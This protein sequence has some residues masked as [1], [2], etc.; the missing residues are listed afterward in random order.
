MHRIAGGDDVDDADDAKLYYVN[1]RMRDC[2][3]A[4]SE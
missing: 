4:K 2:R 3:L 1:A